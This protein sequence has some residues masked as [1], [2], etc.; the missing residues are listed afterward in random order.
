MLKN[1]EEKMN[2]HKNE[3]L[4]KWKDQKDLLDYQALKEIRSEFEA[5][6][7]NLRYMVSEWERRKH[8]EILSDHLMDVIGKNHDEYMVEYRKMD[9][10][11]RTEAAVQR[12]RNLALEEYK[13]EKRRNIPTWPVSFPYTKFKPDILAWDKEHHMTSGAVKF[14]LLAEMLKSQGRITIY[15]QIQIRLGKDR[16]EVDIIQKVI[17]LLDSINE[18]TVYNKISAAWDDIINLKKEDGQTLNEFFSKFETLQYSLNLADGS[19]KEQ[20]PVEAGKDKEYY[21]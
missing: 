16:N 10:E 4:Q 6:H 2:F 19:Y 11:K 7:K 1:I 12:K 8:S 5:T 9:E 14:G 15:E 18:E 3:L 20:D 21:K 13:R 17:N